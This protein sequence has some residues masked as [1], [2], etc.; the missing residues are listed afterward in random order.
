MLTVILA[1]TPELDHALRAWFRYAQP[2]ERWVPDSE[3]TNLLK[4][5]APLMRPWRVD[6]DSHWMDGP[7]ARVACYDPITGVGDKALARRLCDLLNASE[8][9]P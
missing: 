6:E 4:A 5:L 3:P 9:K 1:M 2:I 8:A 7:G